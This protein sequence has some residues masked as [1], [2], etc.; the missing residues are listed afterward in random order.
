MTN[1]IKFPKDF[2]WG[3]ATASYQIEGAWD[4]YGKGESTWD[5]FAHTPGRIRNNDTGDVATDHY[6]LWKKDIGLMKKL[7]LKAYRFSVSWPRILPMGRGKVNQKGVDFYSRL[8][9]GLL[10]ADITPFATLY[11]WDLPQT[12][13]D[14]GGWPVRSTAEAFVEYTDVVTRALGDRVK[15]W[16]THNEPAVV[17]WLG[18]EM[19]VH[20]PGKKDVTL[21]MKAAHHLLLSHGRAVPVIHRN[22]PNSEAGIVL[23]ISWKV[24]ASKSVMDMESARLDDGRWFRWFSDPLYTRGYPADMTEHFMKL[25]A[26]S[27]G[28][29]FVKT[30]DMQAIATPTDFMGLNYYGRNLHRANTP[31]NEPQI[32]FL[33]PKT[34]EHWTD[35]DWENYPDGLTGSL[36]RVYFDYLPR[37]IYISEN[38]ASYS[39]PPDENGKVPDVH[40]IHYLK[41]HIAAAH[42]AIQAG[43]P[44][45]GYFVWS[46]MD[47]FEWS[48][49]YGQRFGI[50]WVDFETRERILK[51]SAK[52]YKSV[53]RKNGF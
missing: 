19:G 33:L 52:W 48:F 37:R 46:L 34:P 49:G 44:L 1:K 25:G 43:V 50:I 14:E 7:G 11:H 41:T 38:G 9:D 23:N 16:A 3:A 47:N 32:D 8:V 29:D 51:D 20:A 31:E 39:T 15:S 4:K 13:E 27:N 26:L 28:F 6:R 40:R 22:S 30:G 18:Y 24:P 42:R 17:A 45:A 53:I 5:R 21:G 10:A 36:G 2:L 35:M 12:L